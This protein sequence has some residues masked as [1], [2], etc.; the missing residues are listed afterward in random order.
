MQRSSVITVERSLPIWKC[1]GRGVI[2]S[3]SF[4]HVFFVC[5][6]SP[7][8]LSLFSQTFF[9]NGL[10][11]LGSVITLDN[12]VY[13]K[14]TELIGEVHTLAFIVQILWIYPVYIFSFFLNSIFYQDISEHSFAVQVGKK[15]VP[16]L[17][18]SSVRERVVD[19]LYQFCVLS[20]YL[21][22]TLFVSWVPLIGRVLSFALSSWLYAFYCFDYLWSLKGLSVNTKLKI[23]ETR[24]YYFFGFGLCCTVATAYSNFFVN[25]GCF[26]L[27]FPVFVVLANQSRPMESE[28]GPFLGKILP[29][30]IRVFHFPRFISDKLLAQIKSVRHHQ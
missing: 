7:A 28:N 4:Q 13:P 26:A 20:V 8:V 16:H 14:L 22:G 3:I 9:L 17:S 10:I 21:I 11:F 23:I 30:E 15:A 19:Q 1:I 2:D 6:T 12:F 25:N 24:P 29:R 18:Y 5:Y 27:L